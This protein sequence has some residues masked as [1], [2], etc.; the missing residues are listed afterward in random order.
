MKNAA[1]FLAVLLALTGCRNGSWLDSGVDVS[2][3]DYEQG[4]SWVDIPDSLIANPEIIALSGSYFGWSEQSG[5]TPFILVDR[6]TGSTLTNVRRGRQEN[7]VLNVN[8]FL[9]TG[10]SSFA[11]MDNFKKRMTVYSVGEGGLVPVQSVPIDEYT[12]ACALGDTLVGVLSGGDA[13]YRTRKMD[14]T[15]L[16]DFCDYSQYGLNTEV[17]SGLMQGHLQ[18]NGTLGRMASYSY[19]AGCYE[20]VDFVKGE[21]V[22]S[23]LLEE[24]PFD[25]NEGHFATMRPDSKVSFVSLSS[26]GDYLFALYDGKELKHYIEHPGLAPSGNHVCIFDWN[27]KY[28]ACLHSA[29]P[30]RSLAWDQVSGR[31]CLCV[32]TESGQYRFCFVDIP[33]WLK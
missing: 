9:A 3:I 2:E 19:Y 17:G 12:T 1:L 18:V 23:V 25:E 28:L 16:S 21:T 30:V 29:L 33:A 24:M 31:L 32:L 10:D 13:R 22:C 4:V 7:E 8:Q 11:V 20:I 6:K 5:E 27:G 15:V 26:S 14:G